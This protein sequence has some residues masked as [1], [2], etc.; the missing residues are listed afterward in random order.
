MADGLQI[1]IYILPTIIAAGKQ[2]AFNI[3]F[4]VVSLQRKQQNL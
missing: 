3:S 1:F 2:S 4:H